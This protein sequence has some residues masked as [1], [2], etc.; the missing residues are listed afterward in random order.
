[1][2]DRQEQFFF[3]SP[4]QLDMANTCLWRGK[5][6]ISL[7]PKDFAVLHYLAAH[8]Y[9]LVTHEEVLKAVWPD[10]KVSPG[11]LKVCLRRIR[12]ALVDSSTKPRFIET[13]HRQGYRFIAP[14]T[15]TQ[16]G[17]GAKPE[18]LPLPQP[19]VPNFVGREAELTQLHQ[20][21]EKALRGER[22]IV[23]I[24]GEPGIGKTTVVR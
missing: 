14:L 16:Q 7:T 5:K 15:T 20:W 23:F 2:P 24:T 17:Q 12:Q 10:V 4:F 3:F 18:P 13:K 9:R 21:L 22:Q 8:P 1:M 6:R 11:V 19:L